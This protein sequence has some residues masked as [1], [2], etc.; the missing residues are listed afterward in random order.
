MLLESNDKLGNDF[1]ACKVINGIYGQSK[2]ILK[3]IFKNMLKKN[4]IF[5]AL[6]LF[7]KPFLK[8]KKT[9]Q[10]PHLNKYILIFLEEVTNRSKIPF[11]CLR[12][13]NLI[14]TSNRE[15]GNDFEVFKYVGKEKVNH[16]FYL[17]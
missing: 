9:K 4:D 2:G 12:F 16:F 15:L 6:Q 14:Q 1:E 11:V 8:D 5:G 10:K 7:L 17:K 3:F 13:Q